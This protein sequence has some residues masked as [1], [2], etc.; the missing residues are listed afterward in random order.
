MH[1]D[2]SKI[3]LY[4]TEIGCFFWDYAQLIQTTDINKNNNGFTHKITDFYD[5]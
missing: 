1:I 4:L 2:A 3:E 5:I